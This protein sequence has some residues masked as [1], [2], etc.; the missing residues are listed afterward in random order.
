MF[1]W[2]NELDL[3]LLNA[4]NVTYTHPYLDQFWLGITNMHKIFWVKVILFPL[5]L[6]AGIYIYK[7][8]VIKI[9][10]AVALGVGLADTLAYRV[11]KPAV[12]RVRPLQNLELTWLRKVGHASGQSF[13]SNHAGNIFAAASVLSWFIPPAAIWFYSFAALVALSRVGLGVHYPSDILGGMILGLIV[14]F[15]CRIF[16]FNRINWFRLQRHVR[17]GDEI[18]SADRVRSRRLN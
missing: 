13:P 2:L 4:M 6:A 9:I 10:V 12:G 14:G 5:I 17:S 7:K 18:S 15:F 16:I 1:E 3:Y 8:E 11:I